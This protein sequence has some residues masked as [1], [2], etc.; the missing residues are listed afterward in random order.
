MTAFKTDKTKH[1]SRTLLVSWEKCAD[2]M[3]CWCLNQGS[4][5]DGEPW[6]LQKEALN[7]GGPT[8]YKSLAVYGIGVNTMLPYS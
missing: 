7:F 3:C 5:R 1:A 4:L 6:W 8:T 2:A